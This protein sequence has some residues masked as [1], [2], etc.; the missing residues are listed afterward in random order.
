MVSDRKSG[1]SSLIGTDKG[2]ELLAKTPEMITKTTD[3]GKEL[4]AKTPEI[5][6]KTTGK[7]KELLAKTPEMI[8]KTK[9][10]FLPTCRNKTKCC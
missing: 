2:K 6:T 10:L 4:L 8:T 5:I 1:K 9:G 7:G 3:K